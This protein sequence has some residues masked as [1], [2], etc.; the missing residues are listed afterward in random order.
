MSGEAE[1]SLPLPLLAAH[2]PHHPASLQLPFRSLLSWLLLSWVSC[3]LPV[4]LPLV[5]LL[6]FIFLFTVINPLSYF[7]G[8]SQCSLSLS[9]LSIVVFPI[10]VLC[11]PSLLSLGPF[12]DSAPT[13]LPSALSG[14]LIPSLTLFASLGDSFE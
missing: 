3:A 13:A 11:F 12:P 8:V 10:L 6:P 9:V 5:G 7:P 1:S 4:P 2:P 14:P